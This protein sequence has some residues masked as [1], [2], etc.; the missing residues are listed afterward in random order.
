MIGD[1][2]RPPIAPPVTGAGEV[3]RDAKGLRVEDADCCCRCCSLSSRLVIRGD[4]VQ[5]SIIGEE[6]DSSVCSKVPSVE[7]ETSDF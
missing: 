1:T 2:A 5:E 7:V 4:D 3:E 6:A